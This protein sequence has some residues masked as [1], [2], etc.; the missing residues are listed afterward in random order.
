MPND[1]GGSPPV[2]EQGGDPVC[3][4]ERVCPE[5]GLFV[6]DEPPAVC[7]RCGAPIPEEDAR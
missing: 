6:E 1:E 2:R 5:C 4:L 7:G 3:W